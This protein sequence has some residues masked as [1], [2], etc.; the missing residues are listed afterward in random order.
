MIKLVHWLY[1]E[2]YD[3]SRLCLR[4]RLN[5]DLYIDRFKNGFEQRSVAFYS[6][7]ATGY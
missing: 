3:L 1:D 4:V 7:S 2:H 6:V 5:I